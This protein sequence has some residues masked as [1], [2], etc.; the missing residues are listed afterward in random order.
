MGDI[1][2][3]LILL[4]LTMMVMIVPM[5]YAKESD[6]WRAQGKE[7]PMTI[8]TLNFASLPYTGTVYTLDASHHTIVVEG[9]W[10]D[11][12]DLFT[13]PAASSCKGRIYT[14]YILPPFSGF[15]GLG[16]PYEENGIG[17]NFTNTDAYI[18][19]DKDAVYQTM[20]QRKVKIIPSR[21]Q[22]AIQSDGTHWREILNDKGPTAMFD[23]NENDGN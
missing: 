14:F 11:Q 10:P 12:F 22:F 1:M 18:R 23:T 4:M 20:A 19:L 6:G 17:V 7:V 16:T 2:K 8:I 21:R 15:E 3:T 9:N 13:L 5:A